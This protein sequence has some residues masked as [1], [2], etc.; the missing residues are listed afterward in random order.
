MIG[1][2]ME[3]EF[4]PCSDCGSEINPSTKYC[5]N[6]G[7]EIPLD[8]DTD[9]IITPQVDQL[10]DTFPLWYYIIGLTFPYIG[11]YIWF[12]NYKFR[13]ESSKKLILLVL[14]GAI[15]NWIIIFTPF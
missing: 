8:Y 9:T 6:C 10:T 14:G 1:V 5:E 13:P 7:E 4:I 11:F 2:I 12:L 15:V 3:I